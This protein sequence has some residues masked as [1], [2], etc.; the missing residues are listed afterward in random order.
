MIFVFNFFKYLFPLREKD[1]DRER[2]RAQA[3]GRGREREGET[4]P[5]R[6]WAVSAESHAG[7]ISQTVRS[8]LEL[9]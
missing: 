8:S 4:N 3:L 2:E 1:R 9:K 6:L 7:L 5:S